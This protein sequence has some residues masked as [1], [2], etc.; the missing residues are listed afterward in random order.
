MDSWKCNLFSTKLKV[1]VK[2]IERAKEKQATSQT[3]FSFELALKGGGEPNTYAC[4]WIQFL[5]TI[6]KYSYYSQ[7]ENQ[8]AN[9]LRTKTLCY[10]YQ[11][12]P[13]SSFL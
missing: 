6:C 9:F 12:N 13:G 1:K 4:P 11:P 10:A 2:I 5:Y 8:I 7:K 3:H